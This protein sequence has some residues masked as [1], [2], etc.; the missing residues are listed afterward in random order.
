MTSIDHIKMRLALWVLLSLACFPTAPAR[1]DTW[2]ASTCESY[3][4]DAY[5]CSQGC[6]SCGGGSS[7]GNSGPSQRQIREA[8]E[9]S[10]RIERNARYDDIYKQATSAWEKGDYREALR[11]CREQQALRDGP[12]V[13]DSIATLEKYLADQANHELGDNYNQQANS[14]KAK[15]DSQLALK[16]YK[17]ALAILPNPTSE[18]RQFVANYEK[19]VEQAAKDL[20]E[21]LQMEAEAAERERRHRPEVEMLRAEAKT[22]ID[23]HPAVAVA[24]LD[25]ALKLLPGDSK[26]VGDWWLAQASLAL[27]EA[28]Y[29][30]AS[31]AVQK[32]AGYGLGPTEVAKWDS[33]IREDRNRQGAKVQN[34][35]GALRERLTAESSGPLTPFPA[36]GVAPGE[37]GLAPRNTTPPA[38]NSN[39]P[40][41]IQPGAQLKSVEASNYNSPSMA[42]AGMGFD[43]QGNNSGNLVYPDRIRQQPALSSSLEAHVPQEARTDKLV[44]EQLAWSRQLDSQKA[45][46]DQKIAAATKQLKDGTGDAK[47]LTAHLGSLENQLKQIDKDQNKTTEAVKKQVKN[48]SLAWVESAPVDTPETPTGKGLGP[49]PV[50]VQAIPVLDFIR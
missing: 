20:A 44:S 42:A 50:E 8:E 45:E 27:H 6:G 29:D 38:Y 28:R 39:N 41:S 32:T 9:E 49:P 36:G 1:A 5:K 13:R 47:V 16:L 22:L 10:A 11:L 2:I 26:I 7:N 24:K 34:A 30:A 14:A 35:F 23:D 33:L 40:G 4:T 21:R 18:Y 15:G 37:A 25:A 31:E 19:E 17:Q 48:L 46:T 3:W 12:N 43:T